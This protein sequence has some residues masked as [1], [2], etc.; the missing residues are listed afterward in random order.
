MRTGPFSDPEC[1]ATLN[2]EFVPVYAVNEDY[3]DAPGKPAVAGPAEK[4]EYDR[5][6]RDSAAGKFSTGTVHCYVLSPAGEVVGTRH[7]ADAA[8][9]KVFRAFLAEMTAKLGTKPGTTLSPP[10]PQS[11][12]PTV[13]P[14]GLALHLTARRL[15]ESGSWDGTAENWVAYT[16]SEVN[17]WLPV[18]RGDTAVALDP[19]LTARLLRHVYPVSENNDPAKNAIQSASLTARRI[20]SDPS[21]VRVR[22]DGHLVMRHDFYHKPDGKVVRTHLAGYADF[23]AAGNVT[24][25]RLVT[26]GANYGGG[27]FGVLIEAGK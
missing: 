2:R 23:D 16:P 14:G 24:R 6:F 3:R 22:L 13:A 26:D 19:A 12:A 17:A 11:S 21:T 18:P 8:K 9:V 25:L 10:K 1:I 15:S 7:V 5:V 4:R 27:T 20:Q